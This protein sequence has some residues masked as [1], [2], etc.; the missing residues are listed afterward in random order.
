MMRA[1]S[2]DHIVVH[3]R[4]VGD[5]DRSGVI[6]DVRGDNGA[7]PY[8]VRWDGDAGE[9][10]LFPGTDAVITP[11]APKKTAAKAKKTTAKKRAAKKSGRATATS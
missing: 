10:L 6:V 8:I 1:E 5:P 11:A 9:H 3:G 4:K 7:P 2:G